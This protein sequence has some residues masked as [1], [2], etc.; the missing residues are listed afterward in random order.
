[1]SYLGQLQAGRRHGLT[2]L[3]WLRDFLLRRLLWLRLSNKRVGGRSHFH[4]ILGGSG[5][6]VSGQGNVAGGAAIY[7][8]E[9][10]YIKYHLL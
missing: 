1:M 2:C 5:H 6:V 8:L 9:H 3:H 7:G 10:I 4:V